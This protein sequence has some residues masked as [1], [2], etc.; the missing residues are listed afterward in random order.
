MWINRRVIAEIM[1]ARDYVK[2]A[3]AK[4]FLEKR[5][6]RELRHPVLL[7]QNQNV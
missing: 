2:V 3:V 6:L 1:C 4:R 7:F 5:P